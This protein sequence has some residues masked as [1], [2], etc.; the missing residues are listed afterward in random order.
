M[1][2][3]PFAALL[4]A[5][6]LSAAAAFAENPA[7]PNVGAPALIT[8]LGQSQDANFVNL[9][10]KRKKLNTVYDLHVFNKDVDWSKYK[11]RLANV[12]ETA[13]EAMAWLQQHGE[14]LHTILE[15]ALEADDD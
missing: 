2:K 14:K 15:T 6:C 7:V 11:E 4:A 12:K 3:F 10:A 8:A 5:L 1:R 13:Q 9:L